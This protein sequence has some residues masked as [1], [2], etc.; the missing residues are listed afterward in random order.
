MVDQRGAG[1]PAFPGQSA[2]GPAHRLLRAGSGR[3][4]PPDWKE[5]VGRR[6]ERAPLFARRR[7]PPPQFYLPHDQVPRKRPG[8]GSPARW[9]SWSAA[10]GARSLA[11][12]VREAVRRVDPPSRSTTSRPCSSA[13]AAAWARSA[14]AAAPPERARSRRPRPRRRR[15]LRRRR[16]LR[17][18]AQPRDRG[19]ARGR[20]ARPRT[21]SASWCDRGSARC[22]SASRGRR[23]GPRRRAARSSAV[24]FGVGAADVPTLLAV[25]LVLLSF[26]GLA[27]LLPARRASRLDPARTL[28]EA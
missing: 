14:S 22:S 18:P 1:P 23:P 20:R 15:D 24:L 25:G 3:P 12:F 11:P 6:G 10:G 9:A 4:R 19:A 2:V 5:V 26:A 16:V 7:R 27:C 8:T 21:W 13:A 17:Q 28:A